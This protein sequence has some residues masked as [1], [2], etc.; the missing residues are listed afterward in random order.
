MGWTW[1]PVVSPGAPPRLGA[2]GAHSKGD[3]RSKW[4]GQ[5]HWGLCLGPSLLPLC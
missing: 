3:I 2:L 5:V 1:Q 4:E